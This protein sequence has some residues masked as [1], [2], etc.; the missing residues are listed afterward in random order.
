MDTPSICQ[1][2]FHNSLQRFYREWGVRQVTGG[3]ITYHT[4]TCMYGWKRCPGS[5]QERTHEKKPEG[6]NK[7]NNT[8]TDLC[9]K[10]GLEGKFVKIFH[11]SIFPYYLIRMC[12]YLSDHAEIPKYWFS[13]NFVSL[14]LQSRK[15]H[16]IPT[17]LIPKSLTMYCHI[18]LVISNIRIQFSGCFTNNSLWST[19]ATPMY[20]ASIDELVIEWTGHKSYTV[21]L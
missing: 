12:Y 14:E 1:F 2:H 19:C 4:Y 18:N 11:M 16:V 21:R 9:K 13:S 10:A 15:S 20:T 17:I 8:F 3:G 5:S 6:K 7:L